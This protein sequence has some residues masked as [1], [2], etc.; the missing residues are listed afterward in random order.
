MPKYKKRADGRYRARVW[1]G[2]YVDG[3]KHYID[4]YSNKSSRDLELKV[5]EYETQKRQGYIA[6]TKNVDIYDYAVQW[7]KT[8]KAFKEQ[9]TKANYIVDMNKIKFFK[10]ITFDSLTYQTLQTFINENASAPTSCV[11]AAKTLKAICKSAEKDKMLP[12][13]T[14][15]DIYD[16]IV[17]PKHRATERMPLTE[18]DKKC[19]DSPE[20]TSKERCYLYILYFTGMRR[21]EALALTKADI[22]PD[23][24]I[25]SKALGRT[26]S[27][28]TYLKEPKTERG[29]RTIP[30]PSQLREVLDEYIPTVDNMLFTYNGKPIYNALFYVLWNKIKAKTGLQAT[31]H[32]FRHNYCTMLCYQAARERN[33]TTKKIAELLGDTEDMVL[34]VYSHII[35]ERENVTEALE[36][37]LSLDH[38]ADHQMQNKVV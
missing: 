33:I 31:P 29:K 12:R 15:E 27:Q 24:I 7:V 19:L 30:I 3:A 26:L 2:S 9:A 37:A 6:L 25:V 21:S 38:Q 18:R 32:N 17:Y 11:R 34:K 5:I 22:T 1:D 10:G 23:G 35:E 20:L 28:S 14:T 16:R 4:L 13:G 8:A 36:N